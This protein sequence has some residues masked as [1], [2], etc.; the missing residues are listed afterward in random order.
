MTHQTNFDTCYSSFMYVHDMYLFWVC[1][2]VL[3][4]MKHFEISL[5]KRNETRLSLLY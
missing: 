2:C 3:C 1:M 5:L 4:Y